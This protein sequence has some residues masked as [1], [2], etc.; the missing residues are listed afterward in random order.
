MTELFH[1]SGICKGNNAKVL[2]LMKG[3]IQGYGRL[4]IGVSSHYFG[5]VLFVL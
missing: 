3:R 4:T 2:R 5:C 1:V